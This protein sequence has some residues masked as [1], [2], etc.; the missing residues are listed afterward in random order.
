[1]R[2]ATAKH[3]AG[4]TPGGKPEAIKGDQKELS[5]EAT[6]VELSRAAKS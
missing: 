2:E 3:Y 4:E 5:F 6:G 1:M